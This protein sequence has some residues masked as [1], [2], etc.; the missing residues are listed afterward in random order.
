MGPSVI[1]FVGCVRVSF[2]LGKNVEL[3][4][5]SGWGSRT[6]GFLSAA[7]LRWGLLEVTKLAH[8]YEL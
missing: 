5:R 2:E 8:F 3:E 6:D 7:F 4:A 1:C